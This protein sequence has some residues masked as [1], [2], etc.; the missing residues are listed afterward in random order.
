MTDLNA[1]GRQIA[2]TLIRARGTL[3]LVQQVLKLWPRLLETRRVDVGQVV[4]NHIQLGLLRLH[5]GSG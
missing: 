5:S 1:G 4:G 3:I 2:G